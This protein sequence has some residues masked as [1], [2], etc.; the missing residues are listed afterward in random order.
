MG[1]PRSCRW[2]SLDRQRKVIHIDPLPDELA[3][4]KR[5]RV[6]SAYNQFIK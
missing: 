1:I 4:E 5:Q 2:G 6:P 3:P